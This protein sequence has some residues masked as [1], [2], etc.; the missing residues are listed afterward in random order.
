MQCIIF[1]IVF[2][3]QYVLLHEINQILE[4]QMKRFSK[5]FDEAFTLIFSSSWICRKNLLFFSFSQLSLFSKI[6][7][8]CFMDSNSV[9]MLEIQTQ[10]RKHYNTK[11]WTHISRTYVTV[12]YLSQLCNI[13]LI[14]IFKNV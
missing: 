7:F 2:R 5:N 12:N 4:N 14:L 8:S 3:K 1:H 10:D 11:N 6:V 13:I 9:W